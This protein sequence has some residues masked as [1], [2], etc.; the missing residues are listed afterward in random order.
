MSS[1]AHFCCAALLRVVACQANLV[2][3]CRDDTVSVLGVIQGRW[4]ASFSHA[5]DGGLGRDRVRTAGAINCYGE[6]NTG[7]GLAAAAKSCEGKSSSGIGLDATYSADSCI[8]IT[9]TAAHP[10]LHVLGT[11]NVCAGQNPAG[12]AIQ[13]ATGIGCSTFGGS[14]S[15]ANKF[16]GTL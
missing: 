10:A 14:T 9:S 1:V 13:A 15:I 8:G 4:G 5:R 6:S 16:L 2:G 3:G 7:T 11:A 12:V